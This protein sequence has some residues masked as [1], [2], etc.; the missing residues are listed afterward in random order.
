MVLN[1]NSRYATGAYRYVSVSLEW[2]RG[3]PR[4]RPPFV[5]QNGIHRGVLKPIALP[6]RVAHKPLKT[7][8]SLLHHTSRLRIAL[9]MMRLYSMQMQLRKT[10]RNQGLCRLSR[11]PLSPRFRPNP[12]PQL[13]P[14]M[15]KRERHPNAPHELTFRSVD[16]ICEV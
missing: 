10:E 12:I 7:H 16:G 8:P 6:Y 2:R 11:V 1:G 14:L 4:L 9:K 15:I 5:Q 3:A 13:G